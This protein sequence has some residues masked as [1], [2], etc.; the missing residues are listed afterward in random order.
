[1]H[2]GIM[3]KKALSKRKRGRAEGAGREDEHDLCDW[4]GFRWNKDRVGTGG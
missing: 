3:K 2:N 1:M 4:S